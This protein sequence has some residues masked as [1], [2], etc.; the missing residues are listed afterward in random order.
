[1]VRLLDG[2]EAGGEIPVLEPYDPPDLITVFRTEHVQE[3]R[4]VFGGADR[5]MIGDLIY[6]LVSKSQLPYT[7]SERVMRGAQY[8]FVRKVEAVPAVAVEHEQPDARSAA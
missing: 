1:M 4:L 8:V 5:Q 6:R 7:A 3:G 2:P